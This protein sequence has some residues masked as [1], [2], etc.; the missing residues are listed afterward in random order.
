MP[1]FYLSRIDNSRKI[2]SLIAVT[3]RGAELV[4]PG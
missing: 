3:K 1:R 2:N 4:E